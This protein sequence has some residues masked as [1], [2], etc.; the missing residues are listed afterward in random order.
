VSLLLQ[1]ETEA[2]RVALL[3]RCYGST[4]ITA[5]TFFA[6]QLYSPICDKHRDL[7]AILDHPKR[8]QRVVVR[9]SRKSGKTT[10]LKMFLA[11]CIL[12]RLKRYVFYIS[13]SEA[14]AM[15]TTESVKRML[16]GNKLIREMPEFGDIRW[17]SADGIDESFA[18]TSW[19]A[20]FPGDE[21]AFSTL[22]VPRGAGQ[23][24][25]GI[26]YDYHTPDLVIIDDLEDKKFINN[27]NIR[28]DNFD[29]VISD[30][31]RCFSNTNPNWQLVYLDTH[32]HEDSVIARLCALKRG[33]EVHNQPMCDDSYNTLMAPYIPQESVDEMVVEARENGT[34]DEFARECM[35]VS[36]SMEGAKFRRSY[37]QYYSEA[38]AP[39]GEILVANDPNVQSIVLADPAKTTGDKSCKSAIVVWGIDRAR[40][41]FYLRYIDKGRYHPS[42]LIDR[43]LDAVQRYNCVAGGIE[44]T[45]L[46]EFIKWPMQQ[47]MIERNVFTPIVWCKARGK[48]EARAG[49]LETIYRRGQ[50]WHERDIAHL[51]EMS[52]LSYPRPAEWDVLD[53]AAYLFEVMEQGKAYMTGGR[54]EAQ[55]DKDDEQIFKELDIR[56]RLDD[57]DDLRDDDDPAGLPLYRDDGRWMRDR[58]VARHN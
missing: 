29:Y 54:D 46:E 1:C 37:F 49:M 9:G 31:G 8:K 19:V 16:V 27:E 3:A 47:A 28:N 17:R 58:V 36:I 12:F 10:W 50:V 44:V 6:D 38:E 34:L 57:L 55:T 40:R 41:R 48:K 56:D 39:Q 14:H 7:L 24:V 30:A 15:A 4:E 2:D 20:S 35:C 53:A 42:Q 26:L 52:L 18:K 32:K 5:L 43:Y 25:R 11:R 23:Q 22:I 21:G 51:I 13:Q 33:W 45:G